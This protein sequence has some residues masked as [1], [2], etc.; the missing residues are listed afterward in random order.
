MQTVRQQLSSSSSSADPSCIEWI[1][2]VNLDVQP[3]HID[4]ISNLLCRLLTQPLARLFRG[5]GVAIQ[6]LADVLS[7]SMQ[8]YVLMVLPGVLLVAIPA[9]MV[10]L[11]WVS[12][13]R[14]CAGFVRQRM[15]PIEAEET[16]YKT[17]RGDV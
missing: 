10:L 1:R 14:R 17:I 11:P 4:V 15:Q 5:A 2:V 12:V 8:V 13:S 16:K 7:S 9:L 6:A 3:S